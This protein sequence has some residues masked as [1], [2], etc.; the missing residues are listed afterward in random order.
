MA[1]IPTLWFTTELG[2]VAV[3]GNMSDQCLCV[4][5]CA[6]VRVYKFS[7]PMD[8]ETARPIGLKNYEYVAIVRNYVVAKFFFPNSQ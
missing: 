6:C 2:P 7:A 5:V 8:S 3:I 1:V 4:C